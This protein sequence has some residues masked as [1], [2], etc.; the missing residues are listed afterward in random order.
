MTTGSIGARF[1]RRGVGHIPFSVTTLRNATET[2][3]EAAVKGVA[4]PIRLSNAYCVALAAQDEEYR[5]VMNGPGVNLP[6]GTP[7][8]WVMNYGSDVDV[9]AGRVRG[10][11]LFV[12][13]LD[14]GRRSNVRH[15]FLGATEDTLA[16][17]V[18]QASARFPGIQIAGAYSP[19]FAPVTEHFYAQCVSEIQRTDAQ[20][21]WVALGT[22]KQ[23]VVG[24]T[25]AEMAQL[26][27]VAV[28]AAFDF[29]AGT[30][31]EAPVWIQNSGTEWL[32]RLATE[33]RRL[34]RRYLIGNFQFLRAAYY[35]RGLRN[36]PA[37]EI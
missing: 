14:I 16:S 33:P 36:L 21:V 18:E 11:S 34:W 13:V 29:L 25:I 27:T 4:M 20:I 28:G 1:E 23:D 22:P 9:F 19:P 24:A 32:F 35:A 37:I 5:A 30:V 31:R 3:I 7:I 10:P 2:I 12:E 6:D 15:F 17:L 26:P 8:P